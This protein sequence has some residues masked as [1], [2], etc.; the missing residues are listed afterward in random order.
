MIDVIFRIWAISPKVLPTKLFDIGTL[1]GMGTKILKI[2]TK[3]KNRVGV[4]NDVIYRTIFQLSKTFN[5]R[6]E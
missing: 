5:S 1:G 3:N 6:F 2:C 4:Q